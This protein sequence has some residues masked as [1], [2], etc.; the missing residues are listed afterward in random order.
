[1]TYTIVACY[2]VKYKLITC[3]IKICGIVMWLADPTNIIL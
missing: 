2:N 3:V 1:M